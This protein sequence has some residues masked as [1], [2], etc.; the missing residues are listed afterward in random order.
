MSTYNVLSF[1]EDGRILDVLQ[2]MIRAVIGMQGTGRK[3]EHNNP[4]AYLMQQ[5][6][7]YQVISWG[8]GRSIHT[9]KSAGSH[10][11]CEW[12]LSP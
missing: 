2:E 9:S 11:G 3:H 1:K 12:R 8:Y 6:N 7:Q 10:C 5:V 4:A